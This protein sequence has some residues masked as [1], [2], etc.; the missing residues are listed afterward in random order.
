MNLTN[1]TNS[2]KSNISHNYSN[3]SDNNK[4]S[5]KNESFIPA[6]LDPKDDFAFCLV[7]YL[8]NFIIKN[9]IICKKNNG[10]YDLPEKEDL[11]DGILDIIR[12]FTYEDLKKKEYNLKN[13]EFKGYDKSNKNYEDIYKDEDEFNS[14]F[15]KQIDYFSNKENLKDTEIKAEEIDNKM[16]HKNKMRSGKSRK[17]N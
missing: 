10:K 16:E 7:K 15:E 9:R 4:L 5:T 13:M 12:E 3:S 11:D 2:I 14:Y 17:Y 8:R 6:I 1:E